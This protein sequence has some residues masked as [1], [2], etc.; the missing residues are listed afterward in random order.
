MNFF[1]T[2]V[3]GYRL[4]TLSEAAKA[5]LPVLAVYAMQFFMRAYVHTILLESVRLQLS[6][7]LWWLQT[8]CIASLIS[9]LFSFWK[10]GRDA[11]FSNDNR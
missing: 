8:A 7:T 6:L 9:A 10:K 3:L 11:D 2:L 4:S 5:L 1:R